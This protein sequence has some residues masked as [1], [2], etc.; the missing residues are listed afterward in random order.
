MLMTYSKPLSLLPENEQSRLEKLRD[1]K[2]LDTH[3]EDTFDM[4]AL[5]AAQVFNGA[6]AFITFIDR[7][8]VFIKS[9]LSQLDLMEVEREASLAS[10]V[11][12]NDNPTVFSDTQQVHFLKNNFYVAL[13]GGVRF[14]AGVPL[15]TPEG[16]NVGAL[17][18]AGPAPGK[19]TEQQL[20][21]LKTLSKI[22]IDKLENRLRYRKSV[23]SQ[24][25]LVNITLHEIKNPLASINL[26][27]DILR[28]DSSKK[29]KMTDMIKSSV[30]RIQTKLHEFLKQSEQEEKEVVL[31]IE[32]VDLKE[33]F[34]RALN[35]FDLLAHRKK[36]V[37]E[38][39]CD[40]FLPIIECDKAKIAD[41]LHNLI[42]NAIKYSYHGS[43]IKIT[44]TEAGGTV[45]IEVK[46]NGQGLDEN[47]VVRLFTKFAKLSSKPTGKETSNGLGL[48]ITKSLVEL[49]RGTIEAKSAGKEKGTSFIVTLPVR[50]EKELHHEEF[51][52]W[53]EK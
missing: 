36:Q 21:M 24:I 10:L 27:N 12:L 44:A 37:I 14:F 20:D 15:K 13:E 18:V 8:R 33:L 47:D 46:D 4:I 17:C 40:E 31:Q 42:S 34:T 11:V 16:Y 5:M 38:L 19:A 45:R 51:A 29:E 3:S 26:A 9:N 30:S 7:D 48:S 25:D 2:I 23:E 52:D 6:D 1:Y 41:V 39:E 35:N 49:H 43:T 53:A 50:Y 22:I 28:K 32:E